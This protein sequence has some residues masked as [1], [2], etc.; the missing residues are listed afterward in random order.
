MIS[1]AIALRSPLNF[2][3]DGHALSETV[4]YAQARAAAATQRPAAGLQQLNSA[5]PARTSTSSWL[6]LNPYLL[7]IALTSTVGALLKRSRMQR[8]RL[9]RYSLA[10]QGSIAELENYDDAKM[11]AAM[12]TLRQTDLCSYFRF[13]LFAPCK[14]ICQEEAGCSFECEVDPV[15]S[16]E[17]VPSWLRNQDEQGFCY[18]LD[19]WWRFDPPADLCDYYD[20]REHPEKYTGYDGSEVWSVVHGTIAYPP[21]AASSPGLQSDF[22][23]ALEAMQGSIAAHIVADL[24]TRGEEGLDAASEFQRR[25]K[26]RPSTLAALDS[27]WCLLATAVS[28]VVQHNLDVTQY[29]DD[30]D[31]LAGALEVF[32]AGAGGGQPAHE[33]SYAAGSSEPVLADMRL[34]FRELCLLMDC[35]QCNHCRMHG[36]VLAMGIATGFQ[37]LCR[38]RGS[39]GQEPLRRI[40]LGALLLALAKLSDAREVVS[41][42]S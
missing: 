18:E 34:R 2:K 27:T 14:A 31:A 1:Q 36:K 32:H 28:E 12:E 4:A 9:Q 29:V 11:M 20:L 15:L 21:G 38:G 42:R 33:S 26:S 22:N 19:G 24:D 35:V 10:Q 41:S 40:E 13:D 3:N 6:V 5:S 17:A 30:A 23:A 7:P 39:R 37:V 25:L 8:P 16:I